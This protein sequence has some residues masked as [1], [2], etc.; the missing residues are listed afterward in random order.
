MVVTS[1]A[2]GQ[3]CWTLSWQ[4]VYYYLYRNTE[5]ILQKTLLKGLS[6]GCA[7]V[8]SLHIGHRYIKCLWNVFSAQLKLSKSFFKRVIRST[9]V[10]LCHSSCAHL[11]RRVKFWVSVLLDGHRDGRQALN[12]TVTVQYVL[13]YFWSTDLQFLQLLSKAQRIF[14]LLIGFFFFHKWNRKCTSHKNI[15][16]EKFMGSN[17][18]VTLQECTT[19]FQM[20][21]TVFH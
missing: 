6:G 2:L 18:R 7:C 5:N 14:W 11:P 20:V 21:F 8:T 16:A 19:Y 10:T 17:S 9:W 12:P 1:A 13:G 4:T 15:W 3:L